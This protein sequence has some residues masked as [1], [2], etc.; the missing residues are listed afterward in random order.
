LGYQINVM[1][2][3]PLGFLVLSIAFMATLIRALIRLFSHD[4]DTE[5]FSARLIFRFFLWPLITLVLFLLFV[6]YVV[7]R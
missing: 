6:A 2:I 1:D 3:V 5:P 4:Y 7:P